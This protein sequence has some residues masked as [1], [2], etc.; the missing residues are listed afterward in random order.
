MPQF[1]AALNT[2][3]QSD[4][5]L[6]D[7]I[8]RVN[9]NS[10]FPFATGMGGDNLHPN[11]TGYAWMAQQW[12]NALIGG[13]AGAGNV[14]PANSTVTM[15]GN[16][17]LNALSSE[18][19]G[20]LT[21]TSGTVNINGGTLTINSVASTTYSGGLTGAG[22]LFKSGTASLTLAGTATYTG[23]TTVNAGQLVLLPGTSL[24]SNSLT[25][26]NNGTLSGNNANLPPLTVLAG[27]HV[28]PGTPSI[29][30]T[31]TPGS[32]TTPTASLAP[33]A[34]WTSRP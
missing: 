21:G 9:L 33:A 25:V 1:N 30:G 19:I 10:N 12:Y 18:T 29:G 6:G 26:Q 11:D 28:A 16:G 24:A 32:L 5:A 2:L 13:G 27:G 31:F 14:L 20:P 15:S 8:S 3:I 17:Y 34:S 23:A 7:N 4:Q 22:G